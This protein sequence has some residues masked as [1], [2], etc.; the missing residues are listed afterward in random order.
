M[1]KRSSNEVLYRVDQLEDNVFCQINRDVRPSVS[2]KV[3]SGV[4]LPGV[5]EFRGDAIYY[6]AIKEDLDAATNGG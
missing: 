4:E 6:E 1:T 5:F 3:R 2:L